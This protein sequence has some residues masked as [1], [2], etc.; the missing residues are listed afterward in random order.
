MIIIIGYILLAVIIDISLWKLSVRN[1][2][3]P[4]RIAYLA[5]TGILYL[6]LFTAMA[7]PWRTIGV[8]ILPKMWLLYIWLSIYIIKLNIV[9]WAMIGLLPRLFGKRKWELGQSVGLPIGVICFILMWWGAIGGRRKIEVVD[10][11]I[12][13]QKLPT[14]FNNYTISQISDLHLGSWGRDT[15]FIAALVDSV[16]ATHPDL[17]VFTGDIVNRDASELIPFIPVLKKLKAPDGVFSIMGNHDY[18]EYGDW[19]TPEQEKANIDTLRAMQR[20]MGWQM[21]QNSHVAIHRDNDSIIIIGVENWG[22][23][24]FPSYGDFNE[25]L[26][27]SERHAEPLHPFGREFKILLSHNPEHWRQHIRK[28]SNVDLTLS[29]HTHAMQSELRINDWRWSPAK[30]RYPTWGGLYSSKNIKSTAHTLLYVNI[31]AGEVG[32]PFRIG[33]NPEVTVITLKHKG[34]TR[35]LPE[36]LP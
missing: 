22:E 36:E 6:L 17:I 12:I 14:A 10:I 5:F 25:A 9:I 4:I 26:R 19:P 16:N 32:L 35:T 27:N 11:D 1:R 23:P 34:V 33:A 21:L 7:L 30:W 20:S 13:S 31:G 2:K 15:T 24:P 8:S 29:G 3:R 28:E 18:G